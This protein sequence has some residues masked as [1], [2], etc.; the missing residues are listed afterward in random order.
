M[1][2][3]QALLS[4]STQVVFANYTAVELMAAQCLVDFSRSSVVPRRRNVQEI[5]AAQT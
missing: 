4:L 2:A 1:T 5:E 3:A